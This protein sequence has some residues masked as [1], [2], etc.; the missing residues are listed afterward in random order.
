MPHVLVIGYGNPLR[1][2]D[3]LG[4]AV[5]AEL[6]RENN[7]TEVEVLPCHQLTPELASAMSSAEA[8]I[9]VDC[10]RE[11]T[12]G[13]FRCIEVQPEAGSATFTHDL[14]PSTLLSLTCE[15]FG[16]CPHAYL[17]SICGCCFDTAESLSSA[18]TGA[19]PELKE[20]LSELI[21]RHLACCSVQ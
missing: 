17:L 21:H 13:D 9:F 5:A 20:V 10:A 15:L 3:G 6:L 14:T 16:V 7:S 4:W 12:R 11:G 18:V 8:V 2:D 19:L 1:G